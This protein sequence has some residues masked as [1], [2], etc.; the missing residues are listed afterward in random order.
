MV[1]SRASRG[2]LLVNNLPQ[3]QNLIK[4]GDRWCIN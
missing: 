2:M 3:L 4:V 1:K